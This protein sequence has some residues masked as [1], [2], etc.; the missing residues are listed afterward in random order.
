MSVIQSKNE[1]WAFRIYLKRCK[2]ILKKISGTD[3]IHGGF[4]MSNL[5]VKYFI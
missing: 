4:S 5:R 1:D 3:T 2:E